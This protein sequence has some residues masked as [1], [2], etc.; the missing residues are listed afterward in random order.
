MCQKLS[1][2]GVMVTPLRRSLDYESL[3]RKII[4]VQPMPNQSIPIYDKDKE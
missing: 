1:N 3:A 4:N 2:L